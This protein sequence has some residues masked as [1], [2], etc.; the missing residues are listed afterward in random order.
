MTRLFGRDIPCIVLTL[1]LEPPP[2]LLTEAERVGVPILR[3]RATTP[4]AIARLTTLLEDRMAPR[5]T[6]HGVLMDILGLGV[7]VTIVAP[8]WPFAPSRSSRV[9]RPSS[10]KMFL[11]FVAMLSTLVLFFIRRGPLPLRTTVRSAPARCPG[12]PSRTP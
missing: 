4:T 2:E 12:C 1:G 5:E 7:L 8:R 6:R 3:T 11:L 10:Q 9:M